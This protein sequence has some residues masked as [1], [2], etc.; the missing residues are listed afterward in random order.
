MRTLNHY[1]SHSF[2]VTFLATVVVL[3]FVGSIGGLYTASK[4]VS[5]G[6]EWQPILK[7]LVSGM[8]AALAFTIPVSVLFSTLL[9][10]G[11]LSADS[12]ITAMKACGISLWKI[13]R[14]MIPVSLLL[15]AI[16][17]YVNSDLVPY[18]HSM[19]P[20]SLSMKGCLFSLTS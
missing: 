1:I 7:M 20:E 10:F 19:L 12:E 11:R 16:C 6:I 15:S 18:S 3:T 14:W 13:V 5:R 2:L 9:V 17:L 8:P 4:L